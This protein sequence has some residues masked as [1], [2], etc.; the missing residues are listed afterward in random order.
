MRNA[1]LQTLSVLALLVNVLAVSSANPVHGAG[2]L[3][4]PEGGQYACPQPDL[5]NIVD[6]TCSANDSCG[7]AEAWPVLTRAKS[8]GNVGGQGR[9]PRLVEHRAV[10]HG[11]PPCARQQRPRRDGKPCPRGGH[12]VLDLHGLFPLRDEERLVRPQGLLQRP[13]ALHHRVR[14]RRQRRPLGQGRTQHPPRALLHQRGPPNPRPPADHHLQGQPPQP[15]GPTLR[16]RPGLVPH[17]HEPRRPPRSHQHE[18]PGLRPSPRHVQPRLQRQ[19]LHLRLLQRRRHLPHRGAYRGLRA[20]REGMRHE[21]P[22]PR[23]RALRHSARQGHGVRLHGRPRAAP[24]RGP[25]RRRSSP[26]PQPQRAVLRPRHACAPPSRR[27]GA[28]DGRRLRE[29]GWRRRREHARQLMEDQR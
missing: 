14:S 20:P 3:N 8:T 16:P 29:P 10:P 15:R 19:H 6:R 28:R 9:P 1:A 2:Y 4:P 13:C 23:H 22:P 12:R 27:L 25:Q 24:P 21:R 17:R 7:G 5:L 11:D 18:G 26:A